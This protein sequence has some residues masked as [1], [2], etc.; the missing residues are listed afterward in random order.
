MPSAVVYR[1]DDQGGL[2][3]RGGVCAEVGQDKR[4]REHSRQK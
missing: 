2:L 4:V 3:E 1:L